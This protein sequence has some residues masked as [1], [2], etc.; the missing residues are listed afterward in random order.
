MSSEHLHIVTVWAPLVDTD[1]HNGALQLCSGSQRWGMLSGQRDED[2]NMRAYGVDNVRRVEQ[3]ERVAAPCPVG[4]AILFN[5]LVFHGSGPNCSD[6]VRWS[7][8]WR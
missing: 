2:G 7:L 8:D 1:L 6:R 5:N 4:S 3:A